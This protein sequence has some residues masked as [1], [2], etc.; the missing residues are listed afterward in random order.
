MTNRHIL[1]TLDYKDIRRLFFMARHLVGKDAPKSKAK[2]KFL[3]LCEKEFLE[4][5][6]KWKQISQEDRNCST[7][8]YSHSVV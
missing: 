1:K 8:F 7:D 6:E 3:E 4:R 5:V 2:A